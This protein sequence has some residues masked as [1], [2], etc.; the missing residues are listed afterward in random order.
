MANPTPTRAYPDYNGSRLNDPWQPGPGNALANLEREA[1][2]G[3]FTLPTAAT[4][5]IA[6]GFVL[7][8]GRTWSQATVFTTATVGSGYT[9]R[10]VALI[11]AGGVVRAVSANSTVALTA[12]AVNTI[13]FGA[14][15]TPTADARAFLGFA[16]AGTAAPVLMATAV[17]QAAFF[18]A[19]P[20]LCGA[21]ATTVTATP[22]TVG[23][24]V[25]LPASG[26]TQCLWATLS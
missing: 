20:V 13:V 12:S 21:S 11:D 1:A 16:F 10:W 6:G 23:T 3:T 2:T 22:P 24:S 17:G 25:S 5:T 15:Y 18:G 19:S 9:V 7:P 14:S 4:L 8:A 26:G